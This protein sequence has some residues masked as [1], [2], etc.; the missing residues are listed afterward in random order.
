ME[1]YTCIASRNIYM[2]NTVLKKDHRKLIKKYFFEKWAAAFL[3][4]LKILI[5]ARMY[6]E[7]KLYILLPCE[8]QNNVDQLIICIIR[9]NCDL[10]L[11]PD[12]LNLS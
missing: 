5:V 11:I 9:F 2:G 7:S 1:I 6:S 3:L 10:F 8:R 12:T 4:K